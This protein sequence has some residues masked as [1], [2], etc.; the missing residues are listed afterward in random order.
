MDEMPQRSTIRRSWHLLNG[1]A[2]RQTGKGILCLPGCRHFLW[3]TLN[4]TSDRI[5]IGSSART[6]LLSRKR[7]KKKRKLIVLLCVCVKSAAQTTKQG[8]RKRLGAS[9]ERLSP[10][11]LELHS[12]NKLIQ[13]EETKRGSRGRASYARVFCASRLILAHLGPGPLPRA[14]AFA[15]P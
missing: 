5:S 8:N 9:V 11:K 3:S 13:G 4:E 15:S 10:G 2:I 7:E 6:L 12:N 14:F 1:F